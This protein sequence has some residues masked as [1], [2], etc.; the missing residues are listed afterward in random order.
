MDLSF[1]LIQLIGIIGLIFLVLS[2]Y[3]KDTNHILVFH[4][5]STI[6]FCIHYFLL[7]AYSGLLI[8]FYEVVRDFLYYK[9]DKD[10]Y[11]FAG[12]VLV[13]YISARLTVFTFLDIF[14]YVASLI[15]GF[16]LTQKRIIVVYGA[17]LT[18]SLWLLYDLYANSYSGI[19]TDGLII[20]SN[21]YILIFRKE[22]K[23]V[24]V[25]KTLYK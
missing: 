15:D 20:L 8:C 16:F 10:T 2:Y 6:L 4:I 11:I 18:Y 14:P 25:S 12:C 1:Y 21:L 5:I 19:I 17:I 22:D 24:I 13:Y 9:T 7:G 23:N 3:R